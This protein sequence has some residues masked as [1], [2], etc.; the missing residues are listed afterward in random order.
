MAIYAASVVL[1]ALS[2]REEEVNAMNDEAALNKRIKYEEDAV[3][4]WENAGKCACCFQAQQEEHKQLLAWLIELR[5]LREK[6]NSKGG[7]R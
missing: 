4:I 7:K 3:K 1:L 5:R 6:A 2:I